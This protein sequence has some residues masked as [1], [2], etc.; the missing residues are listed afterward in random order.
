MSTTETKPILCGTDFSENADKAAAVADALARRLGAPLILAHSVDERGEFPDHLRTRLMNDDRPRLAEQAE[1]LR[2]LGLTFE[3]KLLRGVPDDGVAKYAAHAGARLV[4][5]GASGMG[6]AW[7]GRLVLGNIAERIAESSPVPTLVVRAAAPFEAWARGERPLKVFVG[8]DFTASSEAALRWI[9]ELRQIEPCEVVAAYVDWPPEE[10]ARLG[11]FGAAGPG[12]NLPGM[13]SVLERDLREKVARVLGGENVEV[14][15]LA[16]WGRAD[17]PLVEMAMEAQADLVVVGT[18]QWHGLSRLRHGSVSRGILHHAPMSVACVP[19]PAA[20]PMA[21]PRIR[22][23][24]RVLVA[25][26]HN[27]PHGFAAP[28]GYSIVNPGGTVRLLHNIVPFR[29]LNPMIGGYHQD[30]PSK[31]EHA[32]LVAES[33]AKL[34]A[35]APHEAEARGIVTEVEVT[36]SRET[37]E[38]ICAAAERFGADIICVGSH[39]RPGFTAKVLGS[40][41]LGVLQQS[42]RP[43]LVVWPS[44]E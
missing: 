7:A 38:A 35:L 8:A 23:C 5:V 16:N 43:V 19:T 27:E 37:A 22:E 36:A 11:V 2:G 15:V 18:H 1:R 12:G 13:Q 39:T 4:V 32:Q 26:D 3:E 44:V 6:S 28:Y 20:V 14:R 31:T 30:S 34:R 40:V 17:A 29:L 10:A 9:A 24:Q 21:G 33:E 25:V 42:R 41:A